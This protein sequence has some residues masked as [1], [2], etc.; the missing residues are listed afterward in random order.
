MIVLHTLNLY[1]AIYRSA[2]GVTG[3]SALCNTTGIIAYLGT[4][5]L[6]NLQTL[7]LMGEGFP[8]VYEICKCYAQTCFDLVICQTRSQIYNEKHRL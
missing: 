3:V 8:E 5:A 2:G 6:S 1:T 7:A 4:N